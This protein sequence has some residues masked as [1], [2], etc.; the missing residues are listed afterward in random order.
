M[1]TLTNSLKVID[2]DPY[3]QPY[4][5]VFEHRFAIY[6]NWIQT[7]TDFEGG[8]DLFTRGYQKLGMNVTD[9]EFVYRE[10]APGVNAAFLV[11][12]FSMIATTN[13]R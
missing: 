13:H 6:R 10:W 8:I 2:D 1:S 5:P 9:K 11:G 4:K 3:L 7:I 12:E